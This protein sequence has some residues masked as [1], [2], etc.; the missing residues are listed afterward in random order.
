MAIGTATITC[1]ARTVTPSE[2]TVTPSSFWSILPHRRGQVKGIAD[3]LGHRPVHRA[4]S[5]DDAGVLRSALDA[6]HELRSAARRHLMQR[7]Q[8]RDL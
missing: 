7:K 2:E 5:A 1:R 6:E 8:Q 4:H 3:L